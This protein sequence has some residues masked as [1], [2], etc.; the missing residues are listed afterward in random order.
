MVIVKEKQKA[1]LEPPPREL[2]AVRVVVLLVVLC[3]I[4]F[5][6]WQLAS[7]ETPAASAKSDAVPVYSPYVDVTN[8]P[9]YP[10]QLPSSNPVSSVY[11]SFIVSDTEEP[12]TPSWGT[13]YTLDDAG[14]GLDLDARTAQLRSQGGS[15]MISYGGQASTELAVDC[16]DPQQLQQ[17]YLD[18]IQRYHAKAIDLDI[19][20]AN[21]ANT[22]ANARRATAIAAVQKQRDAEKKPLKVWMTL[23]V[24]S[25]GLTAEGIATVQAMLKAG[26]KLDGVNAMTMD[27]GPGE[28]A[29]QDMIGTIEH[30]LVATQAQVQTLW[31]GAG[32][33]SSAAAA[34]GHV[35]VT[36]MIGVNDVTSERFTTKDAHELAKFVKQRG[37]PRVSIWSLNRDS[38][39]GGAFAKVGELSNTCSGVEQKPLEFTGIFSGLKGTKIAHP[40]EAEAA[41][42]PQTH[43]SPKADDPATSPYPIWR[44]VAAYTS[45]YKVVWQGQIYQSGWWNQG[46]PPGTAAADSP[47][48]PWQPIGPVP[49]GSQAPKLVK[50]DKGD[51][52]KWSPT[53][54]YHEGDRVTFEKLPYEARWY[55]QGEQPLAELPSDPSAPWEP[56]FKYPG[57]PDVEGVE[58]E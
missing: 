53:K 3:A 47:N 51:H 4:G 18:P 56:L 28:G 16:T 49:D 52:T 14:Q 54:V 39:C 20:G 31:R 43:S 7:K 8:T 6:V 45:G 24:A 42:A 11:L 40:A 55:T 34:W 58:S 50:L 46:T 21:L 9:T 13:F 48:G 23:P 29:A 33:P 25:S 12:C 1:A 2:S 10:F 35:G 15:V 22:A 17:A 38:Q 57:E 41:V 36:P 30:S 5:G 44:P 26:V 27:F 37:I 32:L 19:E